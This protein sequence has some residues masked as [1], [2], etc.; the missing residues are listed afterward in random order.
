LVWEYFIG[1]PPVMTIH[2]AGYFVDTDGFVTNL[3]WRATSSEL[4]VIQLRTKVIMD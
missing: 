4:L 3:P 1:D 2:Y